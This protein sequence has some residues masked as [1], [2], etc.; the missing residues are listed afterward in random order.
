MLGPMAHD[1]VEPIGAMGNDTPH[2]VL[3][4]VPQLLYN[5]FRQLFAQVTNPP[6]DS[7]RE[8]LVTATD[9]MMGTEGN[10]LETLPESCRQI[11]LKTPI[12]TN[13]DLGKIR[14]HRP[15][16][17]RPQTFPI[18]FN[19]DEGSAG[20]E[21]AL[22][23][24][25]AAVDAAI[26]DGV[27]ILILSDRGLSRERAA[28]PALLAV[29][30]LHHHLIRNG[31][32]TQVTLVLES[33]EPREVHHFAVL[34]GYGATA[35]N[36]YLAYESL[37]DMIARGHVARHGLCTRP[38]TSITRRGQ[39]RGQ[40]LLQ[41][42]HL[43]HPEL[44]RRADLRGAGPEHALRGQVLH[45]GRRRASKASAWRRSPRR[46]RAAIA[47]AFP[48]AL[49][50]RAGA[51][52]RRRLPMAAR[53]RAP[54]LQPAD[55]SLLQKAVPRQRLCGVQAVHGAGQR[56]E[57]RQPA[58]CAACSTSSSTPTP[59]PL[60][61]VEPVEAIVK[62]FKTGAMSYGSISKEAH[63]AL[64]IAMNRIGG[65][66][67]TGEGGEDPARYMPDANGDSRSSAIKQ[68][69]SGRFGVTSDYLVNAQELQIKMAQGAKPGEGGQ[70]PG[71]KVYPWMAKVRY[72]TPGVGLISPPPHH[73]IYSIEDLARADPRPQERQPIRAHQRQAGGRGGRGHDRRGRGQGPCRRDPD[74]RA[75]RR[76]GRFAQSS[77]KHAGLPWELGVAETHQTLVLNNLRSRVVVETDGQLQHRARR[78]HRRAA[79]GGGVRLRHRPAGG[80]GLH[81]DA[82]LP[83]GYLPGGRGDAEPGAAQEVHG[84]PAARGQLHVLHRRRRCARSMAQLGFR[85]VNEMIGRVDRLEPRQAIEH[86][87]AKGLDFS[88]ILYQ[89]DCAGRAWAATARSRRTTGW[90]MALDKHDA[91]G[92]VR[93]GAGAKASAWRRRCP[94]ATPTAWSARSWA[95][96][97]PGAT[98]QPGL[99]EDTIELHFQGSAGQSFGAFIPS[100]MT[101]DLEGDANDY[102][103]KGLS[104]GKI[105]VYPPTGVDLPGGG[106]H[107][108]RQRGLLRRHRRRSLHPRR[109][110]RTLLRAQQ[111][112]Q[113]RGG[114]RGRPR[115]RVHDRRA[116]GGAGP[117]GPQL[118]APACRAASPM[119]WT[120]T[121]TSRNRC[122]QEMVDLETLDDADEIDEVRGDDPA[123]C[124]S[125]PDSAAA[126][127][128]LADWET[129]RAAASSR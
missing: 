95:A 55:H 94:S 113:C 124:W 93:A 92:A 127:R 39:E 43:H 47:R 34:I 86:W 7:I 11:R 102:F 32:R 96:R 116:R 99:P 15:A 66:S 79:G 5:Y 88:S 83:P 41:D 28:I 1:G 54:P 65:K 72:S 76:H 30:G 49:D 125:T 37:D 78:G 70:L 74:Q 119:C 108:H 110:G 40:G 114:G 68:V 82:R 91:A 128:I 29:A 85:T 4:D 71:R 9:V 63:E 75:R 33:G 77:I 8:E 35:I 104:G 121:A 23:E 106:E 112:R 62:R 103:G 21:R 10:L 69:A 14:A 123:P 13:A 64:A 122:N 118:R 22:E 80:V 90:S 109:G 42:G 101:L 36:P 67:N 117:H 3:S 25:F 20:L 87:K 105:I 24:L 17:F 58:R 26:E 107:H 50:Q 98:A 111:R 115:L 100:G 6:I 52:R 19:P 126:K 16:G 44:L 53:R 27:N 12:L 38:S 61:E 81:H 129:L 84:R 18:L 56:A 120:K 51:A 2:A 97:S 45:R 48:D 57:P 31:K 59:I 46:R 60:E 89:P 73:D